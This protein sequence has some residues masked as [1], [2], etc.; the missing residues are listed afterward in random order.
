[1]PKNNLA[2]ATKKSIH[3]AKVQQLDSLGTDIGEFIQ[4]EGLSVIENIVGDFVERV[5]TNIDNTPQMVVTGKISD[6][7]V[8]AENGAVNV[9]AHPHLLYQDRG[10]NGSVNK[11]Y[12]TPHAYTDKMPPVDVFKQ[13]IKD[14]NIRLV[15]NETY[16]GK[17]SPFSKLTEEEQI[18]K[19]AW[20]MSMKVFQDGYKPR[21]IFSKEIP[22]LI[23]E[24]QEQIADFCVQAIVSSIDVK[25]SAKRVILP[26]K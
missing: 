7:E 4:Q 15:N 14:K 21:K 17:P 26:K 3:E 16:Y 13:W 11:L 1:M 8:K 5:K 10:A 18:T 25:E 19:A 6:I 20:G 9:Y 22:Q 24:L 23:E 12:N 2:K